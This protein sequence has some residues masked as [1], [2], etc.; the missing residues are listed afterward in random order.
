[1]GHA[2]FFEDH[3]RKQPTSEEKLVINYSERKK[4][5]VLKKKKKEKK[6]SSGNDR[7]LV[8]IGAGLATIAA[9][10]AAGTH[11]MLIIRLIYLP[12]SSFVWRYA[13]KY[14]FASPFFSVSN[15]DALRLY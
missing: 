9:A 8:T 14:L 3:E 10:G 5:S 15:S 7:L 1:L 12:A 4:K 2:H 11:F 6:M 13:Q